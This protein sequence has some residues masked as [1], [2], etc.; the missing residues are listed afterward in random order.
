MCMYMNECNKMICI[1]IIKI[2]IYL[3][4]EIEII[5]HR[6]V[7]II[8]KE[9]EIKDNIK[10]NMRSDAL[11]RPRKGATERNKIVHQ[12][13]SS[14]FSD[15]HKAKSNFHFPILYYYKYYLSQSHN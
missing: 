10:S 8:N 15:V 4:C 12:M 14:L 11:W 1:I 9:T 13:R 3:H 6:T 5:F 7:N 2:K